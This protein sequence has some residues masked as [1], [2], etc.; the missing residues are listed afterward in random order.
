MWKYYNWSIVFS[1][2]AIV[3]GYV[4]GGWTGAFIV[5]ILAVLETTLS[6]DNAVVN[7]RILQNWDS[8]WRERFLFWGILI[9][10]FG[11]R[12][13]FPLAIVSVITG[14]GPV[15]V[16]DLAI[17]DPEQYASILNSVHYEIAAFGGAFLMMV[18]LKFFFDVE[19]DHHWLHWLEAPLTNMGKLEAIE[20]AIVMATILI[21]STFLDS[22]QQVGFIVAGLIGLIVYIIVDALG[23]VVSDEEALGSNIIKQGAMGFLY[24]EMLDMSF[25]L[26]S[27]FA[28]LAITT[29]ILF[30][31]LGLGVGAFFVRSMTI[32]MVEAGTLKQLKY[33]EHSAFYSI[34]I[35]SVI[36]FMSAIV[37]VPEVFTGLVGAVLIGCGVYSSYKALRVD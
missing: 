17:N 29:N 1:V 34:M 26:D 19:K 10:V 8:V 9:A 3:L 22:T 14:I 35:L 12:L 32:H 33:L 11:V 15:S 18:S 2:L 31:M 28:G 5:T 27:I 20:S 37:H 30:L 6:F 25:S 36:L 24:L 23:S 16:L 7:A 4:I 21:I 13:V